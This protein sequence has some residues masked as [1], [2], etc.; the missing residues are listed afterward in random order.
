[1]RTVLI[2][3]DD[4]DFQPNFKSNLKRTLQEVKSHDPDWD[5]VYVGRKEVSPN[6]ESIIPGTKNLVIPRSDWVH[7]Y[8]N[9]TRD[10]RVYS[11]YSLL[12]YPT[13]FA[14]DKG[15]YSDTG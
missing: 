8:E 2:L 15:W 9:T 4:I 10:L 1:M 11:A 6:V 3:E 13:H 7:Y 12:V 5:L 14:G